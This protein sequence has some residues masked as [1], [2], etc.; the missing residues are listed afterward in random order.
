MFTF[1]K[2]KS[3]NYTTLKKIFKVENLTKLFAKK[4]KL[5]I[6]PNFLQKNQS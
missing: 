2:K 3:Q 6:L 1:C 5:K 4:S